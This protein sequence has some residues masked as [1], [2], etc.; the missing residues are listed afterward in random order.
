MIFDGLISATIC[1]MVNRTWNTYYIVLNDQRNWYS[2]LSLP[3][4]RMHYLIS[5][6]IVT[7]VIQTSDSVWRLSA[8]YSMRIELTLLKKYKHINSNLANL[9]LSEEKW[10]RRFGKTEKQTKTRFL[11]KNEI[12]SQMIFYSIPQFTSPST[13]SIIRQSFHLIFVLKCSNSN[14]KFC[15]QFVSTEMNSYAIEINHVLSE[16]CLHFGCQSNGDDQI[17]ASMRK[18]PTDWLP[19]N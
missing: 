16:Y 19:F 12:W 10:S 4:R 18:K 9:W 14:E 3:N 5:I 11:W 6:S 15:P 2:R 17:L 8:E 1:R 13:F 7:I